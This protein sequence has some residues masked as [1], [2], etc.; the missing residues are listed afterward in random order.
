MPENPPHA[1]KLDDI[2]P[3]GAK[4]SL[5]HLELYARQKVH[6]LL[7]GI[8]R[9]KRI[10]VSPDFDHHKNYQPGDPLRHIDWKVSARHDKYFVKRYTEDT[11]LAVRLVVDRSAS[12][13]QATESLPSKYLQ[14]CRVTACLAYLILKEKDSAGLVLASAD[15]LFWLPLRSTQNHLVAFLQALATKQAAAEDALQPCLK[16]VRDRGE[17][18]GLVVLVTDL[19]Y[20][21]LPIQRELAQLQAQG[22]ELLLLNLRDPTEEDFPFNR[23]VEFRDLENAGVRHRLDTIP[24]RKIYRQEYQDL[25]EEWRSW[26]RK[27]AVHFVSMRTGEHVETVLSEYLVYRNTFIA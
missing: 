6:G 3:P 13:L 19:M 8:H 5:R 4:E 24:L 27:Y 2:L 21:P 7:H 14:A 23:W 10:G 22:H 12:M 11:S 17:R 20:D 1:Y 15:E 25:L 18:R 26:C 16:A 9:S